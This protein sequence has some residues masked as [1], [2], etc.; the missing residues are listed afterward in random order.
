GPL[1]HEA[2]TA[3]LN[4]SQTEPSHPQ[5]ENARY[6]HA[7]YSEWADGLYKRIPAEGGPTQKPLIDEG[8][9]ATASDE[10][11]DKAFMEKVVTA[12]RDRGIDVKAA[13]EESDRLFVGKV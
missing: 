9:V 4:K 13:R 5:Y 12:V 11:T 7:K 1:T 2:V 3:E 8:I 10:A 6:N